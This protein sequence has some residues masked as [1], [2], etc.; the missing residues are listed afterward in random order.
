MC[1]IPW[2]S[3]LGRSAQFLSE[4]GSRVFGMHPPSVTWNRG[5]QG[6]AGV[7]RERSWLVVGKNLGFLFC[8]LVN[9]RS[10]EV[11]RCPHPDPVIEAQI[12]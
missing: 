9:T 8:Q 11:K 10:L 5:H 7:S 4:A 12:K 3:H 6:E 2:C 1:L